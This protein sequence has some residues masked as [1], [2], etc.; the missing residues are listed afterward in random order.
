MQ[1]PTKRPIQSDELP[2]PVGP[3]SPAVLFGSAFLSSGQLALDPSTGKLVAGDIEA[4]TRQALENLMALL[5][6]AGKSAN[7]VLKTT[8]YVVNISD[9]PKVNA[10]YAEYFREPFPAQLP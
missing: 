3:Y 4:Q 10:I 6:T 5:R 7:Q 8:I 1:S 2:K 9:F